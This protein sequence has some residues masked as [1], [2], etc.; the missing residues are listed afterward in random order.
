VLTNFGCFRRARAVISE[1]DRAIGVALAMNKVDEEAHLRAEMQDHYRLRN[2]GVIT[3]KACN[4][5]SSRILAR[6]G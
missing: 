4:K 5:A 1:I 2:E 6:F 3:P